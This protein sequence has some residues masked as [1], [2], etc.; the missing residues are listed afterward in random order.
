MIQIT[1]IAKMNIEAFHYAVKLGIFGLGAE[2][3]VDTLLNGSFS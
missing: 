3:A 1:T 2:L